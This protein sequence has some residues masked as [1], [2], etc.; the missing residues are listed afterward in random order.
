MLAARVRS[1]PVDTLWKRYK[2]TMAVLGEGATGSVRVVR[3]RK[4]DGSLG[5][6]FALKHMDKESIEPKMLQSVRTEVNIM[7]QIDHPNIVHLYEIFEDEKHLYMILDLCDGGDL[8]DRIHQK[9]RFSEAEASRLVSQ[10]LAAI[11]YCH[12][13]GI[14]HRDLKLENFVF[15]DRN[16]PGKN[17]LVLIDFGLSQ[18]YFKKRS[19]L[20]NDDESKNEQNKELKQQTSMSRIVGSAYYIAPEVVKGEYTNACDLWSIGVLTF[21]LVT[22]SPPFRGDGIMDVVGKIENSNGVRFE[23]FR[24]SKLCKEFVRGLLQIDPKMRWSAEQ[25]LHHDWIKLSSRKKTNDDVV[26]SS[27]VQIDE[28]DMKKKKKKKRSFFDVVLNSD[29]ET[30]MATRVAT[31]VQ[32]FCKFKRL[33][34]LALLLNLTNLDADEKDHLGE[35]FRRMD[36]NMTG[37]LFAYELERGF[38]EAGV[39]FENFHDIFMG[40]DQDSSGRIQYSQFLAATSNSCH[41]TESEMKLMFHNVLDR[42]R[43]GDGKISYNDLRAVL[44]S[45]F[46]STAAKKLIDECDLTGDK[47]VSMDEFLAAM[48]S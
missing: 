17:T 37:R 28:N 39:E 9:K 20:H 48:K 38:K 15:K 12:S 13:K 19:V 3:R 1:F 4:S 46:D 24:V 8:F 43:D 33:K 35:I 44:G 36:T 27:S 5:K 29:D 40:L 26:E 41:L 18:R 21:M 16:G 47:H 32:R 30:D 22:G 11:M 2:S 31:R 6:K 23:P 34:R 45:N 10:M 42:D 7:R 25:A 14:A